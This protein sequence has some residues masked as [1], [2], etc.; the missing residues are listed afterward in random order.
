MGQG[1]A[2]YKVAVGISDMKISSRAEDLLIT[3]SLGSCIGLSVYDFAHH[4]GGL[5]HCLLPTAKLDPEK[6]AANPCMFVDSG[7]SSFLQALFNLG[8]QRRTMIA[9]VA[10]GAKLFEDAQLFNVGE[11]NH[12]ML[13]KILW[14]NNIMVSGEDVGGSIPRT[15]S[16][17]MGT[18][19][20]RLK[21]GSRNWEI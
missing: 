4:L 19:V 6:A 3:Y 17:E 20:T 7:V 8:A 15:M 13:R 2:P 21:S 14:K 16:L 9:K 18:G 5:I 1:A 11:R 10:G 12:T